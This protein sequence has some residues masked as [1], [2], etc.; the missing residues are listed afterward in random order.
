MTTYP[1]V[2][3]VASIGFA[4]TV[5][6]A[7]DVK[8]DPQEKLETAIPEGIRLLE[9]KEDAKFLKT[10]MAPEDFK[11]NNPKKLD[12][13]VKYF[14][15]KEAVS[16]LKMLKAVRYVNPTFG[17]EGKLATYPLKEPIDNQNSIS[18]K[19]VDKRWYLRTSD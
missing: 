8:P 19:K 10:F 13:F 16:V 6:L 18:F 9:A 11:K 3:L 15:E 1:A 12:E 14:S 2:F 7:E 17:N 5:S 4:C